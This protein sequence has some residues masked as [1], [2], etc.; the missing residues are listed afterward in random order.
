MNAIAK[1]VGSRTPKPSVPYLEVEGLIKFFGHDRAV[2]DVSFSIPQGSFLTLL[3]PSGC[4][5]TTTLMSIAGLHSIDAGTIRVGGIVYTAVDRGVFLA[6]EKRDIGMVFQS[7]AIWP[8]MTVAQ[9]VAYPLEIRKVDRAEIDSRVTDVL[10]LVGLADMARKM[11]TQLSGGQQQRAALARAI[12]SHPRLLLFDE[13]LSNLDLKLREQMRVELKRIQQEVGITSVY[14]THDQ[15]EALVM[16]DD[17]IVM[18]K[19]RIEQKGGP[20]QIYTSPVNRYVSNFIGVA[21]LLAGRIVEITGEGYGMM[22]IAEGT[23]VT[24]RLPC[25]VGAGI[26]VG[27]QAVLS[28]RPEN[29]RIAR[30]SDGTHHLQ[31]E[32]TQ[33]IFLG[34]CID[35]RV[36]WGAFEWK[37]LAHPR[38]RLRAGETVFLDL[39]PKHSLAVRP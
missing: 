24:V 23:G 6:P 11:A 29:V 7:Y 21:N 19:G 35:C 26:A 31:G 5:K 1:D 4:G 36:R 20:R 15:S 3:G 38:L 2:D 25:R 30:E 9:N 10:V 16:S 8:H 33:A 32:V 13:P 18:S 12:V 22:E 28:V 34:N 27:A 14:V 39:D 17:I 37:V